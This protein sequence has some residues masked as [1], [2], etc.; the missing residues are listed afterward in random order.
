MRPHS[1]RV[2]KRSYVARKL[3]NINSVCDLDAKINVQFVV[4]GTC[5]DLDGQFWCSEARVL[6]SAMRGERV[7]R[8]NAPHRQAVR[9]E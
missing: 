1:N 5:L 4:I 2:G 8:W 7:G 3:V 6:C 9:S